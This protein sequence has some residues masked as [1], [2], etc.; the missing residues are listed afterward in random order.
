MGSAFLDKSKKPTDAD[1]AELLGKTV[2]HWH[3]ITD[4]LAGSDEGLTLEWKFYSGSHGWHFKAT[5]KK[6]AVLY[7]IPKKGGFTASMALREKAIEMLRDGGLPEEL[8]AEIESAKAYPEGKPAR[9]EVTGKKKV[10]IVK[11]LIAVKLAS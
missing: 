11:K 1:L 10:D 6:R 2:N 8:I 9:I 4:H 7:M 5:K 3:A